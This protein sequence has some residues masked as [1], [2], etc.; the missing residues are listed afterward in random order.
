MAEEQKLLKKQRELAEQQLAAMQ[1]AAGATGRDSTAAVMEAE[2]PTDVQPENA[3][4]DV[5]ASCWCIRGNYG[6]ELTPIGLN[7]LV[8]SGGPERLDHHRFR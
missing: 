2:S 7:P 6:P 1:A 5:E 4:T 3:A 8:G